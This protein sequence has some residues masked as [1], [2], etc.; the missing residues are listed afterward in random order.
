MMKVRPNDDNTQTMRA[1][2]FVRARLVLKRLVEYV[3][4]TRNWCV[5]RDAKYCDQRVCLSVCLL[6][7]LRKPRVQTSRNFLYVLGHGWILF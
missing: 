3:N 7:Y 6:A 4:S 1:C 2:A 5:G